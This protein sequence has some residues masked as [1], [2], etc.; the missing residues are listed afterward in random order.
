MPETQ[1]PVVLIIRDGWGENHDTSYDAYNAVKLA[2]TPVADE[3]TATY[4]RTE[5]EACGP[6]VGLPEGIMGNSEVGH[7]NIGAGR[8][9]DQEIVRINKGIKNGTV[10]DIPTLQAA[11]SNVKERGSALHFL[12]LVSDAGVHSM[13]DHLYGLLAV[14]KESGVEK[15]YL[16]AF[17]DGRDTGPFSGKD[18]I[19]AAEAKMAELGVGQV[20]SVAGRYWAMDRDNRW[21]RVQRAYDC[22]TGRKIE[23]TYASAV[24]A[25]E[26]QYAHPETEGTKGDEFCPP[27][28]VVDR[29]GQP[30]GTIH[31]GDSVIFF[32]FRGDRP[33]ELTR[34]FIEDDFDA[35][36]RGE[37]LDLYFATLSEYQKGLC[38]NVIFQ[39]PEKM[40][41]ILGGYLAE[42]GIA[43]FR[44]AETEKFPHVTFFFNDYREEPFPGEDRELVP[45]RKDC[46]TYD[47]KPEMSA[48]GIR[49][50]AVKAI[51]SGKYGLIVVNFANP[52]M[53]GHT[54]VLKACIEACEIVDG[55]VGDLLSAIDGVG[56]SALI[57]ADHG[58]SDQLWNHATEGAHTAHTLNPVEVVVYSNAHKAAKLADG[59]ALGDIAPTILQLMEL[60]QPAT[61]TGKSLIL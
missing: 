34:A 52:D 57:T 27:A 14:A 43:Q 18:F 4:P 50:A 38:P 49:D 1:K 3:L 55:C 15:I 35:F 46:A 28:A 29:E 44:C 60:E 42:K 6:A 51:E 11:F 20:A 26:A 16:H 31:D 58:N 30:I 41:D 19:E 61:M 37:K 48:Y 45:S 25:I 5:I 33:R 40:A 59:G 39:K 9:V 24:E 17:T 12:G 54:G 7:Q 22:L 2:K 10:K 23:K 53:V 56:G 47:E 13:L 32:N 21:D 8:V 36:D